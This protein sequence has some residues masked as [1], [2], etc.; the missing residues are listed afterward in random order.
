MIKSYPLPIDIPFLELVVTWT[1]IVHPRANYTYS[2]TSLC[3][4]SLFA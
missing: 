3:P 2:A 4:L 1:L